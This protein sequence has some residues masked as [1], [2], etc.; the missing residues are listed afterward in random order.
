MKRSLKRS[1]KLLCNSIKPAVEGMPSEALFFYVQTND[2]LQEW[3]KTK[4]DALLFGDSLRA[5]FGGGGGNP[6]KQALKDGYFDR[7]GYEL[8]MAS[9]SLSQAEFT[10]YQVAWEEISEAFNNLKDVPTPKSEV[11]LFLGELRRMY[12]DSFFSAVKNRKDSL[13]ELEC[14]TQTLRNIL[15]RHQHEQKWIGELSEQEKAN[16]RKY[17]ERFGKQ[18]KGLIWRDI[19]LEVCYDSA[20]NDNVIRRHLK[21]YYAELQHVTS[22]VVRICQYQ[23]KSPRTRYSNKWEDGDFYLRLSKGYEL[24]SSNSDLKILPIPRFLEDS[25]GS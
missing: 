15:S 13:K 22:I 3:L 19:A 17:Y 5:R 16:I 25:F 23:R 24:L 11:E 18:K 7:Q 12:D 14:F 9:V 2:L 20:K 6:A 21:L 8:H 4:Y 10:L 1:K